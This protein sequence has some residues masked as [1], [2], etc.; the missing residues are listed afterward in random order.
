MTTTPISHVRVL[1]LDPVPTLVTRWGDTVTETRRKV[2]ALEDSLRDLNTI[3]DQLAKH[4]L[5]VAADLGPVGNAAQAAHRT[6]D[7]H[8]ER[9]ADSFTMP[10]G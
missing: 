10:T 9:H 7:D 8:T 3:H 4:G 5:N 6:I 1:T 2:T